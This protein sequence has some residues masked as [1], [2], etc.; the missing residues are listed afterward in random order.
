V[1]GSCGKSIGVANSMSLIDGTSILSYIAIFVK[2]NLKT[3]NSSFVCRPKIPTGRKKGY[4]ML[5]PYHTFVS[6]KV[7]G[8]E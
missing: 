6:V 3:L 5:C 4:S 2:N 8:D 7:I 1:N